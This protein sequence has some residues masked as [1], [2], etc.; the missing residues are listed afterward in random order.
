MTLA[1]LMLV[2]YLAAGIRVLATFPQDAKPLGAA[3]FALVAFFTLLA[4][5]LVRR[6][7]AGPESSR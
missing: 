2:L 1:A 6:I 3:E 7:L 4:W 5:P